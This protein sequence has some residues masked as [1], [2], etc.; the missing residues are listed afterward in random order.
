MVSDF[1]PPEAPQ[2]QTAGD[3][4]E[5]LP[6]SPVRQQVTEYEGGPSSPPGS[7]LS[8]RATDERAAP[9]PSSAIRQKYLKL[10]E[11]FVVNNDMGFPETAADFV[12]ANLESLDKEWTR[13]IKEGILFVRDRVRMDI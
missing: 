6:P 4:P 13:L 5:A 10:K 11:I 3:V 12:I 7:P 9:V 8:R 1:V 2:Q